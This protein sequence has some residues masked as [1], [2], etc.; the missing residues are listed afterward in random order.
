MKTHRGFKPLALVVVLQASKV[1]KQI[2][3]IVQVQ[4]Y[5]VLFIPALI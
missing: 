1:E 4:Q 2:P 5:T 3:T